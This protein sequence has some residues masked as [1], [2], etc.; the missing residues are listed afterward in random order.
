MCSCKWQVEEG[1]KEEDSGERNKD[2]GDQR[3]MA[4]TS[5]NFSPGGKELE[6]P[7]EFH[8][9]MKSS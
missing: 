3:Y 4:Q 7:E 9:E 2:T 6:H 1:S 8:E 5:L